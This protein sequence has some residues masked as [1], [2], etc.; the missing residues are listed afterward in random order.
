MARVAELGKGSLS[1]ESFPV[2]ISTASEA[3]RQ[4]ELRDFHRCLL[5]HRDRA[6]HELVAYY[7]RLWTYLVAKPS[8]EQMAIWQRNNLPP[9]CTR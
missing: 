3:Y 9:S 8:A 4:A 6:C 7:E 2:V 1:H 5:M